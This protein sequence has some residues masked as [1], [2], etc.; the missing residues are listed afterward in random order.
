MNRSFI[1]ETYEFLGRRVIMLL[2]LSLIV[3]LVLFLV[4][5]AFSYGLQAFLLL[6]GVAQ[7]ETLSIPSW[8]PHHDLK[9]VLFFIFLIAITRGVLV[10][11]Q[12]YMRNAA[13]EE[14]N[15]LQRKRMLNWA[16]F[17]EPASASTIMTLFNERSAQAAQCIRYFQTFITQTTATVFIGAALLW[18]SPSISLIAALVLAIFIPPIRKMN[19]KIR[20]SGA[21]LVKEWDKANNRLVLSVKNLLLLRIYGLEHAEKEKTQA[22]LSLYLRHYLT[23]Q[24][25]NGFFTIIPQALGVTLICM[26]VFFM[27][28]RQTIPPGDLFSFFYLFIRFLQNASLAGQAAANM[29]FLH[30]Q[31]KTIHGWWKTQP[32]DPAL[33]EE[34]RKPA[35]AAQPF[36]KPV[37]WN[38]KDLGFQYPG[39]EFPV[40]QNFDLEIAPGSATVL[41]G[42]SG[43]GKST[44]LNLL[45]G[46]LKPKSGRIEV[47]TG[48]KSALPLEQAKPRLLPSVGYVGAESFLVDGTIEQNLLYGVHRQPNQA[49]ILDALKKAECQ[50]VFDLPSGLNHRLTEQGQGLSSGQKQRLALARALLRQ[51]KA[52]VLDEATANLDSETEQKLVNTF[53]GLKGQMTIIA[54]THRQALLKIADQVI[55]L[56]SV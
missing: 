34:R 10:W 29:Y 40:L 6:M 35:N 17:G 28:S 50:F 54:V 52:L 9:P 13:A 18:L 8:I 51:P 33:L 25:S 5:L 32:H 36:E 38:C 7:E 49:E 44:L 31:I 48:E 53:M 16:F 42:A 3:G 19:V 4:E 39:G 24:R 56:G 30:P 1:G 27:K 47:T 26:L 55:K 45:L 14:F 15:F 20:E 2:F 12:S 46:E 43:V 11:A 22:S 23:F 37:G 21:G 41:I